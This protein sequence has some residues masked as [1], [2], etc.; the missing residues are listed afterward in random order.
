[1]GL[2]LWEHDLD[3][4]LKSCLYQNEDFVLQNDDALKFN[5]THKNKMFNLQMWENSL[6]LGH[7]SFSQDDFCRFLFFHKF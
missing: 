2:T 4:K 7:C 6:L 3:D 5:I 1:M